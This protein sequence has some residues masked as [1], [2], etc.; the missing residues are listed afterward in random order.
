MIASVDALQEKFIIPDTAQYEVVS[1]EMFLDH[2]ASLAQS[3]YD[4]YGD[5]A[6]F[7][8][9]PPEPPKGPKKG[10]REELLKYL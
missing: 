10:S 6:K 7:G 4:K 1:R 2:L 9:P 8:L 3:G 5:M